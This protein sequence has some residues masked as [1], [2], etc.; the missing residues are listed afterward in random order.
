MD[1][2]HEVLLVGG[3]MVGASLA[4]ALA[5]SGL[6]LAVVEAVPPGAPSQPSYD[7]RVIALSW[8]SRLILQAIGC[9]DGLATEAEPIHHI[10]V[11]DRGHWGLARLDCRELGVDALG[12]VASA[13]ALGQ[14][15]TRGLTDQVGL[16]WISPGQLLSF[17]T[18]P[19][20]V[21]VT[22]AVPGGTQELS[23][24]LL[25]AADGAES[26]VRQALEPPVEQWPYGQ[27][28]VIANVTPARPHQNVAYER[29]TPDGPLALLP[30]TQGR[31]SL[32]WT[33]R[34]TRVAEV[35]GWSDAEFLARLQDAFG[36]RLGRFLEVG[37]RQAYPLRLLRVLE[38]TQS[39]VVL[40]GNAAHTLHPVAG[41][42]FNLGL[43][44][45]AALAEVLHPISRQGQDPGSE[46][47]L[48]RYAQWR[49]EDQR[50]V[51][52][53]TDGLVRLFTNPWEPL[54]WLR[55]LG[56]VALDLTPP[57]KQLLS[58]QFMGLG[59]KL[60]RLARGLR[61]VA[62]NS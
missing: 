56:L 62:P 15:L 1:W 29:F 51:A 40:I 9:W 46:W 49:A 17:Q 23:V 2:D 3:G 54:R 37:R 52:R 33:Q 59:G 7:D 14:T 18:E 48:A 53:V 11:S 50:R 47:V 55:N 27:A 22:L 13:R 36:Y 35:Q 12:Y 25:V 57:A 28:A 34:E 41:Q 6:R 32:V 26:R 42:G 38:F 60:P 44:D 19:D 5:G 8:G 43:R 39:R 45:V 4:R 61:L 21:R 58:R 24:G 31:C 20:R 10:H 16:T 30:M